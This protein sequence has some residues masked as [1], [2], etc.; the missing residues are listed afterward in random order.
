MSVVGELF[1]YNVSQFYKAG[2]E[3]RLSKMYGWQS[4]TVCVSIAVQ[5]DCEDPDDLT[6][7][8]VTQAL[9]DDI[10]TERHRAK[11]IEA[12]VVDLK[13]KIAQLE[14]LAHGPY[15][16]YGQCDN[17]CAEAKLYELSG[18]IDIWMY[19]CNCAKAHEIESRWLDHPKGCDCDNCD[20]A[21]RVV[22]P[23]DVIVTS[24]II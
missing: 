20:D 5:T 21:G 8:Q 10:L 1:E 11:A 4:S 7:Y 9:M 16:H 23:L 3:P 12:Q 6:A 17:C 14:E 15:D 13:A 22:N 19:C 18:G 2:V 24:Y